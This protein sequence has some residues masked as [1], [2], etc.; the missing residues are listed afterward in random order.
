MLLP[1]SA[2]F[3]PHIS[4]PCQG[5][6]GVL[7]HL[8]HPHPAPPCQPGARSLSPA[9]RTQHPKRADTTGAEAGLAAL[10]LAAGAT[11]ARDPRRCHHG[12]AP[13]GPGG[14]G[15]GAGSGPRDQPLPTG[16]SGR[17]RGLRGGAAPAPAP[18][19]GLILPA[20]SQAPDRGSVWA[21]PTSRSVCSLRPRWDLLPGPVS[22]PGPSGGPAPGEPAASDPTAPWVLCPCAMAGA[23]G[24]AHPEPCG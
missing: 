7:R 9:P 17:S 6:P 14:H 2:S 15:A 11:S 20:C 23:T 10:A 21:A 16:T 1:S 13:V 8:Q 22:P 5:T 12:G 3:L 24:S 18:G 19:E 4:T